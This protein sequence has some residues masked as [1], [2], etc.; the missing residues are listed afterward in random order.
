MT[1]VDVRQFLWNIHHTWRFTSNDC[2]KSVAN[3]YRATLNRSTAV[4]GESNGWFH[5]ICICEILKWVEINWHI[6]QRF[7]N[8]EMKF[9]WTILIELVSV[10]WELVRQICSSNQLIK[11]ISPISDRKFRRIIESKDPPKSKIK[12]ERFLYFHPFICIQF[13]LEHW[14]WLKS[15]DMISFLFAAE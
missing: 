4:G 13:A 1:A 5:L 9:V 7:R 12:I 6:S 14:H 10:V 11:L 3:V 15:C 2:R 8:F